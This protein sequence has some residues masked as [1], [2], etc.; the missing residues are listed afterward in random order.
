MSIQKFII[1]PDKQNSKKFRNGLFQLNR[2]LLPTPK[3]SS[4]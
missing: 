1:I 4:I 3:T 2:Y